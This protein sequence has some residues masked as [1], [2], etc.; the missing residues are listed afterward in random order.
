MASAFRSGLY[1]DLLGVTSSAAVVLQNLRSGHSWR[2]SAQLLKE[3]HFQE[4]TLNLVAPCRVFGTVRERIHVVGVGLQTSD[5][6][7][8]WWHVMEKPC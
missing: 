4:Q 1:E 6:C 3:L 5:G 2:R 7:R 8:V